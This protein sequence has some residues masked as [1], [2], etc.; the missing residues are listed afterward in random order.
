VRLFTV[1]D[2]GAPRHSQKPDRDTS[3]HLHIFTIDGT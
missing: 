3:S 2:S 1:A